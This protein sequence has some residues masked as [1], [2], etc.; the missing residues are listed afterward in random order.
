M[1]EGS[2]RRLAWYGVLNAAHCGRSD[3]FDPFEIFDW[4]PS[5]PGEDQ[6]SSERKVGI[7]IEA[8]PCFSGFRTLTPTAMGSGFFVPNFKRETDDN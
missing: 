7:R 3:K 4:E 6:A 5:I 8:P 2:D 1:F